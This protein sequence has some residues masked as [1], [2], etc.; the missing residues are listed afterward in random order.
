MI[1]AY[2]YIIISVK[3]D[4]LMFGIRKNYIKSIVEYYGKDILLSDNMKSEKNFIQHGTF[5]VYDHSISVASVCV[6]M[7]K[8]FNIK[9]DKR[10]LIRGAL[11]HDYFLYDWHI[12]STKHGLHG[13]TYALTAYKNAE[14]DFILNEKEKNM[15]L[16]HMFPLNMKLPKYKESVILCVSDKLCAI[17]ETADGIY[18]KILLIFCR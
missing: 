17:Y 16:S 5:S 7:A 14:R 6:G 8:F 4:D 11:L 15:I 12:P 13:F 2:N 18:K 10:T 1:F 3:G 9:V